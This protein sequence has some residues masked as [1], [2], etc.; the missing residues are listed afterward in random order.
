MLLRLLLVLGTIVAQVTREAVERSNLHF[1]RGNEFAR[2]GNTSNLAL[3]AFL[4]AVSVNPQHYGALVNIGTVLIAQGQC[5]DGSGAAPASVSSRLGRPPKWAA[6]CPLAHASLRRA[7]ALS[8][9]IPIARNALGQV[10]HRKGLLCD[11]MAQ[12]AAGIVALAP[13]AGAS[14]ECGGLTCAAWRSMLW[15][16]LAISLRA[17][18]ARKT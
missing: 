18:Q 10:Y 9:H 5:A 11:A 1:R 8:P 4:Q 7:V 16:N 6:T 14:H 17:H 3:L 13:D 2:A 12:Y 15:E